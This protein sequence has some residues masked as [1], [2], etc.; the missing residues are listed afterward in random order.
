M[1]AWLQLWALPRVSNHQV[2]LPASA[3]LLDIKYY[4]V[5]TEPIHLDSGFIYSSL[6]LCCSQGLQTAGHCDLQPFRVFANCVYKKREGIP[7]SPRDGQQGS[8]QQQS[9]N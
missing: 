4:W 3:I 8:T 6:S 9:S 5:R 2:A 1:E 7:T